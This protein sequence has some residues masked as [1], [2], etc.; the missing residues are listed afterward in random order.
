MKKKSE[1]KSNTSV[2]FSPYVMEYIQQLAKY[3]GVSVSSLY[4]KAAIEYYKIEKK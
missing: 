1:L 3:K 2:S 4:E